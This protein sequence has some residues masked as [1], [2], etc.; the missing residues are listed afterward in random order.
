MNAIYL[1]VAAVIVCLI[2]SPVRAELL[3]YDAAKITQLEQVESRLKNAGIYPAREPRALLG[4]GVS[5]AAFGSSNLPRYCY[6]YLVNSKLLDEAVRLSG[7][8]KGD[9]LTNRREWYLH[10]AW[11]YESCES[12]NR[13]QGQKLLPFK[14]PD[15]LSTQFV[16]HP[17]RLERA[18]EIY[19]ELKDKEGLRRIGEKI[20]V[21]YDYGYIQGGDD[22]DLWQAKAWREHVGIEPDRVQKAFD[23]AKSARIHRNQKNQ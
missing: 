17:M 3:A 20:A 23:Y 16:L 14:S 2:A 10:I 6:T 18:Y 4:F 11:F 1:W 12:L 15:R 5:K 21:Q 19:K 13:G 22:A 7:E 8:L 9:F